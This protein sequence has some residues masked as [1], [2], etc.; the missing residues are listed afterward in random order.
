M[1]MLG[2]MGWGWIWLGWCVE[3]LDT[4]GFVCVGSLAYLFGGIRGRGCGGGE[5]K[6]AGEG[7]LTA[8]A[9]FR[10]SC[11]RGRRLRSVRRF[12]VSLYYC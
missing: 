12:H 4:G 2:S 5:E 1:G 9:G 8:A 7:L 3:D 6:K 11:W 10:S